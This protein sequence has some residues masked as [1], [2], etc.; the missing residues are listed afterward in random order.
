MKRTAIY[1]RYSTDLQSDKSVEDQW[2]EGRA[3]AYKLGFC[4]VAEFAD[5]AQ[6]SATMIGRDGVHTLL[7]AA[8][9][10]RIDVVIVESLDRLSRNQ[11]DLARIFEIRTFCC[12]AKSNACTAARRTRCRSAYVAC[13]EPSS[14][15]ISHSK[16]A[17]GSRA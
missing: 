11:A 8:R 14:S 6:T 5:N 10:V 4:V 17:V 15:P 3:H 13:R 12:V 1:A 2:A 7:E 16:S 9:S